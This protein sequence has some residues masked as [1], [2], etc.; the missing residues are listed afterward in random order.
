MGISLPSF[1]CLQNFVCIRMWRLCHIGKTLQ[2]LNAQLQ[3][4]AVNPKQ[5]M[6]VVS[7]FLLF[8]VPGLLQQQIILCRL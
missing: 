8:T 5:G 4:R 6:E 3:A 7:F 1:L 2:S